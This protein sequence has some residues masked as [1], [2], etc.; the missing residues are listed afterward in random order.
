MSP[1]SSSCP[2]CGAVVVFNVSTSL[3]TV[4]KACGSIVGR[5]DQKLEDL[6]KAGR[7]TETGAILEQELIGKYEGKR[8]QLTG[9]T[10]NKHEAGGVWDEWYAHFD[11]GRWGWL[12][13]AQ[14][15][16]YLT[17][18]V[19]KAPKLLGFDQILLGRPIGGLP[20]APTWIAAEKGVAK[21]IAAEGEL[22]FRLEPNTSFRF[23]DLSGKGGA[24]A[25]IDYG[26]SPPKLYV[27]REVTL[28][29]IGIT[30][31]KSQESK[32][33][34]EA[35]QVS[36]PNCG[37]ALK[38]RA[39]DK[40]ERV[41][42]P[43]CSS[44]LDCKQGALSFL[45]SLKQPAM[46]LAIPLGAKGTLDGI[47]WHAIGFIRRSVTY[48]GT[49]YPWDEYLL[50]NPAHGFRWLVQSDGHW[51]FGGPVPI[52]EVETGAHGKSARYGGASYRLFQDGKPR[53]DGV[54]GEVY[55]QV[56]VGDTSA[57]K[58]FI[59]PPHML[60][61]EESQYDKGAE[62]NWTRL[63]YKPKG[64]IAT[65]FGLKPAELPAQGGVAPNQVFPHKPIFKL[66]RRFSAAL[67]VL[68]LVITIG[69]ADRE[70]FKQELRLD[71]VAS[72][73][74]TAV[75]FSEP[76]EAKGDGNIE[77]TVSAPVQ[78]T[79]LYVQGD[80][81]NDETGLVQE[82]DAPVEYYSGVD[83]GESWSEGSREKSMTFA[84]VPPGK[85]TLRVESQ[86]EKFSEPATVNVMVREDVAQFVDFFLAFLAL[87]FIPFITLI[88]N[89]AFDVKRWSTS[90]YSP[91]ASE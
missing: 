16:Y 3:V 69:S 17:F 19:E 51:S 28:A 2:A 44:L 77:V 15:K 81:I 45:Q 40:S 80:I 43:A 38:L 65:A 87:T 26:E 42:C 70:L 5:G 63:V 67:T 1:A 83:D 34:V 20:G 52:G 32:R 50:F 41:A 90:D 35:I 24:F 59:H 8:F 14:G 68:W 21:A 48:E 61:L 6:G 82:F 33:S 55:W 74:Q 39:P 22:P 71:P 88:K 4:C 56:N 27:G 60:S 49:K 9:R 79:W 25:T 29:D 73:E 36:C 13:E 75:Y 57:S 72:N 89:Y 53:V 85:Y 23:T 10:Q 37:A 62:I 84:R 64:E 47:E 91:Y 86:W 54:Y 11:D 7:L 30:P 46:K 18:E 12:A 78:N 76:F 31:K 58:D 66:W